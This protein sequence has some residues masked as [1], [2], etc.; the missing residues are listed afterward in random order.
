MLQCS[1]SI[2]CST[3]LFCLFNIFSVLSFI[4]R[5]ALNQ[6]LRQPI[7]KLSMLGKELLNGRASASTSVLLPQLSGSEK[8]DCL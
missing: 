7:F 1:F 6:L 5:S 3:R 2:R 8:I 4:H